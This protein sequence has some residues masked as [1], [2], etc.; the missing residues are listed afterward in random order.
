MG[1]FNRH[2]LTYNNQ[3]ILFKIIIEMYQVPALWIWMQQGNTF[4]SGSAWARESVF[5]FELG[6]KTSEELDLKKPGHK[7]DNSYRASHYRLYKPYKMHFL[8]HKSPSTWLQKQVECKGACVCGSEFPPRE[9][10]LSFLFLK[11][12]SL[13]ISTQLGTWGIKAGTT[14]QCRLLRTGMRGP[15]GLR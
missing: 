13:F 4:I 12:P 7:L 3:D 5:S 8:I 1:S 6:A 14:N 15:T 10:T 2:V 9:T 11:E